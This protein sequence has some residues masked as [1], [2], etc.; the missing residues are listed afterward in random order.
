[1]TFTATNTNY[2]EGGKK[3]S[4]LSK[5]G[6]LTCKGNQ[7]RRQSGR[8]PTLRR[9]G[10]RERGTGSSGFWGGGGRVGGPE[11]DDGVTVCL[12]R[13]ARKPKLNPRGFVCFVPIFRS[14]CVASESQAEDDGSSYSLRPWHILFYTFL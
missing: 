9:P 5:L 3:Q 7:H 13:G 12:M 14:G 1:M 2:W 10:E 8:I 4:R 11:N 6:F